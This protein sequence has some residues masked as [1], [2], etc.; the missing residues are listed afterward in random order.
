LNRGATVICHERVAIGE[1]CKIAY[2]V[3]ITDSEEHEVPGG[4]PMVAPVAIGDD[5]WLGA[6]TVGSFGYW[7]GRERAIGYTSPRC[8]RNPFGVVAQ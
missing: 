3:L 5:V 1:R 6:R 4:G 2:D 7:R 8:S